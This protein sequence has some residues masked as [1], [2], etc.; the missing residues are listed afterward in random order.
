MP[1]ERPRP[2]S[3]RSHVPARPARR[4]KPM[5]AGVALALASMWAQ[6]QSLQDLYD[7]AR[8]YDASY[9]AARSSAEAA[10][11]R[12]AQSDALRL[13]SAGLVATTTRS[14]SDAPQRAEN[15]YG[16]VNQIALTARQPIYNRANVETISQS[17]KAYEIAVADLETAEQDLIVRLAQAYFDVLAAH[18]SLGTTQANKKAVT[19]QLASAKRNF[20]VGTA[21]ITDTREAQA[22]FDRIV[23]QEIAVQNDLSTKRAALD[24]LVGRIGVAPKPLAVPVVLPP[25]ARSNV[26]DWLG[27]A[28]VASPTVRKARLAYDIA[29]LE[30]NKARAGHLPTLDLV[31]SVSG[32]Q[33][34]GFSGVGTGS[35][36]IPGTFKN[37]SI[38]LQ[39][40]VPVFSGFSVQN[41]VKETL[42]LAEKSRNDL[43]GA[44]RGV[45]LGTRTAFLGVQ[46]GQ[47]L[48]KALEAAESSSQLALEATQL[49]FKVGV[50]VTLD[51]LNAQT[52]LFSTRR[53][54]DKARYDLVVGTL[55]LRQAS[56]QLKPDD[57]AGVNQLLAR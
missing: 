24:T 32:N 51:V 48:V 23:A 52:Q 42:D 9:L 55:K 44:R 40:N 29:Q 13:P 10:E 36:N 11:S 49:G 33:N 53:D 25:L 28:D 22:Q 35:G 56:G 45:A 27:G 37:A 1:V 17:E 18:D 8:G 12:L 43:E 34:T 3:R 14:G 20:E 21:T 5:A 50:R 19:E 16:T 57:I 15:F 7:A 26:D 39:L 54:L 38:G 6:A 47:A 30:T 31:G 46:S 4:L 41:R 2:L